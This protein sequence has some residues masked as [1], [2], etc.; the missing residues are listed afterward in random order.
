MNAGLVLNAFV[1]VIWVR[2]R[3][4]VAVLEEIIVL[5]SFVMRLRAVFFFVTSHLLESSL[6]ASSCQ[7][8]D[9]FQH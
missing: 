6:A 7:S 9:F 1:P 3:S 2:A 4:R 5:V 8:N